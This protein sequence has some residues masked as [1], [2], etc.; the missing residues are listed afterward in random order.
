MS[1]EDN[2]KKNIDAV[3]LQGFTQVCKLSIYVILYCKYYFKPGILKS[4]E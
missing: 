4:E 1:L 3:Y 2:L